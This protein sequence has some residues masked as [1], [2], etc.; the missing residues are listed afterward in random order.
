MFDINFILSKGFISPE[1]DVYLKT[2]LS[3]LMKRYNLEQFYIPNSN[4]IPNTE[5]QNKQP[6]LPQ[7]DLHRLLYIHSAEMSKQN[8]SLQD[9]D[10]I[11]LP[12]SSNHQ[13]EDVSPANHMKEID[14]KEVKKLA[15]NNWNTRF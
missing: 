7:T 11:S 9:N 6:T 15:Q 12:D 2:I 8:Q 10:G 14:D 13:N 3:I 4:C 5:I 1:E